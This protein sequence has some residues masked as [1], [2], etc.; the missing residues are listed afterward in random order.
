MAVILSLWFRHGSE[1]WE[2]SFPLT[3]SNNDHRLYSSLDKGKELRFFITKLP[4]LAHFVTLLSVFSHT[5]V[6]KTGF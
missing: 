2:V 3:F 6:K 1:S 5:E 4:I